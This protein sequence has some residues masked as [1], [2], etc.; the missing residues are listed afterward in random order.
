MY[1]F[2]EMQTNDGIEERA[3]LVYQSSDTIAE[4]EMNH[5]FACIFHDIAAFFC[6][7]NLIFSRMH[8]A[9]SKLFIIIK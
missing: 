9:D 8:I 7:H 6:I 2:S 1:H 3:E 4:M 5:F